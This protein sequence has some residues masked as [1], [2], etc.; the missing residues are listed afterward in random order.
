MFTELRFNGHDVFPD[1]LAGNEFPP[2]RLLDDVEVPPS[3][4]LYPVPPCVSC[5][6]AMAPV[7]ASGWWCEAC[8]EYQ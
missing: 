5:F 3:G 2:L 1:E 7:G 4:E 8:Q 6:E